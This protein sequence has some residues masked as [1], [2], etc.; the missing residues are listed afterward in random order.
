MAG[1][2]L[3]ASVRFSSQA[4]AAGYFRYR[5]NPAI[6]APDASSCAD[7]ETGEVL[8]IPGYR[9]SESVKVPSMS[10]PSVKFRLAGLHD[11]AGEA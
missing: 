4:E 6:G 3:D 9:V 8:W 11:E 7:A 2:R 5:K 1:W 10:A